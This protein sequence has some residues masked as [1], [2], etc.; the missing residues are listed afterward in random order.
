MC[1][2]L[3]SCSEP[4]KPP[5]NVTGRNTSSTSIQV[6]WREVPPKDQNGP[7]TAYIVDYKA[8]EGRFTDDERKEKIVESS[9]GTSAVLKSLDKFVLYNISVRAKNA[10]GD[11][12]RSN[13]ILVRTAED[14]KHS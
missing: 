14:G 11:G 2:D 8:V 4:A 1:I 10:K 12:P 6:S 3:L 7:I 9:S 5:Q 13:G